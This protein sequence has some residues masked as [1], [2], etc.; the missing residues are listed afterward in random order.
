MVVATVELQPAP[1][2][3]IPCRDP[4]PQ[5]GLHCE[6]GIRHRGNHRVHLIERG[7]NVGVVEWENRWWGQPL[8]CECP[9]C[10]APTLVIETQHGDVVCELEEVLET[11][12]CQR[13]LQVFAKGHTRTTL[14]WRCWGRGHTGGP[15]PLE[16]V[17]VGED[18]LG[19]LFERR[20]GRREGEAVYVRHACAHLRLVPGAGAG[21]G[22]ERGADGVADDESLREAHV[23]LIGMS[24]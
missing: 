19:R 9:H 5:T 16:G 10:S 21:E 17:A 23:Y 3:Y 2:P 4:H 20:R 24:G 7:R 22:G 15:L 6:R 18:G 8:P 11:L 12:P 13:C 14:C 1:R